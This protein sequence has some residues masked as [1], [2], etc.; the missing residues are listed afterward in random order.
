MNVTVG[1]HSV[2][3]IKIWTNYIVGDWLTRVSHTGR[4]TRHA[5]FQV[6]SLSECG[7]TGLFLF[8]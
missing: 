7:R 2:N 6:S 1:V 5:I 8:A 3:G 4:A